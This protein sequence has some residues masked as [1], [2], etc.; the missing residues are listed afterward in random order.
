MPVSLAKNHSHIHRIAI[1]RALPGLG[2]FLCVVPA[3]RALRTAFPQAVITLI[4]LD[5]TWPLVA[6]YPHYIDSFLPFPGFP[7]LKEKKPDVRELLAFLNAMQGRF[8]L[9]LQM[10]GNGSISNSFTLLL[11]ANC[12]A[13][14]YLPTS[15]C[16]NE[17]T[18]LP[19]P[20][21][22]SEVQRYLSLLKFLAIP[23][24]GDALEFPLLEKDES[25]FIAST[26]GG[27]GTIGPYVCLHPGA[28]Q[29]SK[30]W[31]PEYFADL[32]DTAAEWGFQVVLTGTAAEKPLTTAVAKAMHR[33]VIDLA[34]LTSLGALA[35]WLQGVSLLICNDTGVS[36]L[37]AA[38]RVPS[39]VI[40]TGQSDP[41]RWAPNDRQQH[42][43]VVIS[44]KIGRSPRQSGNWASAQNQHG[45]VTAVLAEV[46]SLLNRPAQNK[47]E[48]LHVI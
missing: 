40:F 13:G 39:V 21:H 14:F 26:E 30:R 23:S 1:F 25:D 43:V 35:L 44:P 24:Q 29:P 42:R 28:S 17:D 20:T 31:P 38:L 36:H 12:T 22:F 3:L 8:D 47:E 41:V 2:D 34:G 7:G 6:R 33:P 19:Y 16:P 9:A 32:G 10:H 46:Q 11:N 27:N 15:H 45:E 48:T 5:H 18:F 37:A 4:G